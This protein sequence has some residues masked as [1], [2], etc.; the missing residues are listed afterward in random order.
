MPIKTYTKK[1]WAVVTTRGRVQLDTICY[2]RESA[3][4]LANLDDERVGNKVRKITVT[5][6]WEER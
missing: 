5:C 3:G 6:E 4:H 1:A 2:K